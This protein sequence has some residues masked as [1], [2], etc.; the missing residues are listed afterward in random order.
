MSKK[1]KE[2][3]KFEKN[4]KV[5]ALFNLSEHAPVWIKISNVPIPENVFRIYSNT[6]ISVIEKDVNNLFYDEQK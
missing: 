3:L 6:S 5:V 4:M 2:E 1:T